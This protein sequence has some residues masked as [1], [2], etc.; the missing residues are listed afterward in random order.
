MQDRSQCDSDLV[1]GE[2]PADAGSWTG[3]ER[4]EDARWQVPDVVW[5]E[6][7][8]VEL[9][10]VGTPSRIIGVPRMLPP[11]GFSPLDDPL[12]GGGNAP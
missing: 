10:S 3:A 5:K 12:V 1:L 7:V 8:G 11:K 9:V 2:L 4:L 6:P